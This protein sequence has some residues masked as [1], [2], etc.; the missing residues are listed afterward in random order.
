MIFTKTPDGLLYL[1]SLQYVTFDVV[2]EIPLYLRYGIP[3]L[4][5]LIFEWW[6]YE[7]LSIYSGWLGT[8]AL[9]TQVIVSNI[10]EMLYLL[11]LGISLAAISLVGNSLGDNK[12]NQAKR[13]TVAT[14]IC[15]VIVTTGCLLLFIIFNQSYI[16]VYTTDPEINE[17]FNKV[18]P[19]F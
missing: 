19:I 14:Y 15:C 8:A 13:Y 6:S 5:M 1:D 2:K 12:P 3:S 9:A 16:Q 17:M 10:F 18:L 11:T 4:F 7:I